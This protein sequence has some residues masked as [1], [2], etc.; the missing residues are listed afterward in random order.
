[1]TE[2]EK[3]LL[4]MLLRQVSERLHCAGCNDFEW[5]SEIR[6]EARKAMGYAMYR[7]LYG[8]DEA[9]E[10]L[11]NDWLSTQYTLGDNWVADWFV[12][13]LSS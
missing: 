4:V 12:H 7:D 1:M 10:A 6:P 8:Q 9:D 3:I 13:K 2:D 5:P 11:R